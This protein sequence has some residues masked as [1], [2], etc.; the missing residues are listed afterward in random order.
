VFELLLR[1]KGNYLWPAM[2]TSSFALDGPGNLNEELADIYGVVMGASHHEPCLRASEE[3]DKVRGKDS[4]YGN[5][6]NYYIN[7]DGLLRYWEDALK[8]SGKYEKA[9]RP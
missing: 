3:W 6:W 8:R 1:L 2:W 7:K 5:D 4:V 9:T